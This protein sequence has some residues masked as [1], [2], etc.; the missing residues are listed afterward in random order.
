MIV[1]EGV[2]GFFECSII[3]YFFLFKKKKGKNKGLFGGNWHVRQQTKFGVHIFIDTDACYNP[4]SDNELST[5][6]YNHEFSWFSENDK[7]KNFKTSCSI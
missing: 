1:K 3:F 4:M 5:V 6:Y 7:Q 2:F